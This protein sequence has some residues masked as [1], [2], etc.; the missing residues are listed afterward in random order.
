MNYPDKDPSAVLQYV[1][2]WTSW[3]AGGE[4]ITA[5]TWAI[6]GG[7]PGSSDYLSE[8]SHSN[9]TTSSTIWLKDGAAGAT[10][11]LTNHITTD[12]GRQD[13]RTAILKVVPR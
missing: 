5:S 1:M 7:T 9:N 4:A 8:N 3:L 12:G 11:K 13:S 2:D 10:Y 6:T